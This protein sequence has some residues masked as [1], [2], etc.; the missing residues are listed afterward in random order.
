MKRAAALCAIALLVGGA[1]STAASAQLGAPL[2]IGEDW[3]SLG[4]EAGLFSPLTTFTDDSY[5]ESKFNSAM[6]LSAS[7]AVWPMFSRQVGIRVKLTRSETDGE[8]ST[9]ELAPIAVNDP[10]Q[11][12]ATTELVGR[13]PMQFGSMDAAPFL[14]FGA[15]LRQYNWAVSVHDESRF[16]TLTAATGIEIRP[17]ALGPV[18]FT[19]ELRGYRSKFRAFG[20]DDGTWETGT[21]A[22]EGTNIGFYGGVVGGVDNHDLVLSAGLRYSL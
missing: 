9:S 17:A 20:I 19:A 8:N 21:P 12:I 16:F 1:T 22:R 10:T 2:R 5:G 7:A 6:S 14:S 4:I 15:G 11:W 18:G 3:A 13:R